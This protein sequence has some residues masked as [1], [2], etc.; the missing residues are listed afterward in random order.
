MGYED[1][2]QYVEEPPADLLTRLSEQAEIWVAKGR[3]IEEY[4]RKAKELKEE[5]KKLAEEVIPELMAEAGMSS[6][7]L[8][9]GLI[10]TIKDTVY[11]NIE[12]AHIDEAHAYL[13]EHG[14]AALIK[15]VVTASFGMGQEGIAD[16]VLKILMEVQQKEMEEF[17][18]DRKEGVHHSTLRA[19]AKRMFKEIEAEDAKGQETHPFRDAQV[20]DIFGA[21]RY[22]T[23]KVVKPKVKK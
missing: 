5:A 3:E 20:Q 8:A 7:A 4:E 22:P 10:I 15:N 2:A 23:A 11:A 21:K 19:F 9:D 16:N 14:E 18:L 1:Y 6:F 17:S 12:D 13:K